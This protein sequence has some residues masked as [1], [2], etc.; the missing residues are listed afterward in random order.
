[1]RSSELELPYHWT[2]AVADAGVCLAPEPDAPSP[3]FVH[4]VAEEQFVLV[5]SCRRNDAG[6][7][8]VEKHLQVPAG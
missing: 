4:R 7:V 2:S 3:S 1:M 5:Q 6:M 8:L